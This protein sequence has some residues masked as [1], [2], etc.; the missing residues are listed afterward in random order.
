MKNYNDTVSFWNSQGFTPVNGWVNIVVFLIDCDLD[1]SRIINLSRELRFLPFL[2]TA[3]GHNLEPIKNSEA[4][5]YIK[6]LSSKKFSSAINN[7]IAEAI[8][9]DEDLSTVKPLL[10]SI[11]EGY[12]TEQAQLMRDWYYA[13]RISK[14]RVRDCD[15]DLTEDEETP[16][17][18]PNTKRSKNCKNCKNC[19]ETGH[20]RPTCTKDCN[21]G[22][23]PVHQGCS[24]PSLKKNKHTD[25]VI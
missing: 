16:L 5:I 1:L 17:L 6:Y 12:Y 18:E 15:E 20:T 25:I 4:E 11:H 8:E 23:A 10:L 13:Y 9:K 3:N 7:A 2:M 22:I 21:C 24:C 14:K 19:N